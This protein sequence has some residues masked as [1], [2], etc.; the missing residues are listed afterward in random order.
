MQ[1]IEINLRNDL[2]AL[3]DSQIN[4]LN[5]FYYNCSEC[6]SE[7][8]IIKIDEENIEFKC[9]NEHFFKMSIKDYLNKMK[10]NKNILNNDSLLNRDICNEHREE[11]LSYCFDCKKHLCKKCLKSGEHSYHYKIN[12]IEIMPND[13]ILIKVRQ[14]IRKDKKE[15]NK[16]NRNKRNLERQ[17]NDILDINIKKIKE[18]KQTNKKRIND[19]KREVLNL[20]KIKY[21]EEL[22]ELKKD[23]NNKIKILKL[24]YNNN[25]NKIKNEYNLMRNNNEKIYFNKINELN[26]KIKRKIETY[27]F[28]EK[29]D[30]ISNYNE[31]IERIYN[32]YINYNNNYYN[33]INI[34]NICFKL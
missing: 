14:I 19:R 29:I 16:L 11:Y 20:N 28:N 3:Q 34:N 17:M 30:K 27:K 26:E 8:E 33:A 22:E 12:I 18:M 2:N 1:D 5:K 24:K 6:P 21:Y 7:I 13:E 25:I 31:L 10:E 9:N 4:E 23:Y 32:T 15:I